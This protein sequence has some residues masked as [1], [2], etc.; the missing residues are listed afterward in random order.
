LVLAAPRFGLPPDPA[1]SQERASELLAR[2]LA[3]GIFAPTKILN[4]I[5]ERFYNRMAKSLDFEF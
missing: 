3:F 2:G 4:D 1:K 5:N